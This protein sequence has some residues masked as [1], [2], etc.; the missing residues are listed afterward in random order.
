MNILN[1][2]GVISLTGVFVISF[3]VLTKTDIKQ[4]V[5]FRSIIHI[6]IPI[7]ML[8]LGGSSRI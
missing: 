7:I 5:A 4:I 2:I 6:A 3:M 8:R 1:L